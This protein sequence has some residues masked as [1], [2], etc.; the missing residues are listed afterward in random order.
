M[1]NGNGLR[2]SPAI[3]K[4]SGSLLGRHDVLDQIEKETQKHAVRIFAGGGEQI[5]TAFR[6]KGWPIRFGPFGRICET[7]EQRQAARDVLERN[8]ADLEDFLDARR[9]PARVVLPVLNSEMGDVLTHVNTDFALLAAW[10][11][12]DRLL[13]YTLEKRVKRKEK[14]YRNV[15]DLFKEMSDL[16][17]DPDA[18]YKIEV[19]GFPENGS[20]K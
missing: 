14:I 19:V 10:N 6:E 2:R 7:F 17:I 13:S 4:H 5:N 3:I 18:P 12:Y 8:A 20:G 16:P 1:L 9:I 15:W 11:G